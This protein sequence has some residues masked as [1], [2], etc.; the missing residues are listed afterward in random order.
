MKLL[1]DWNHVRFLDT[2][3]LSLS[4]FIHTDLLSLWT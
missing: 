1:T 2:H 4:L 3:L